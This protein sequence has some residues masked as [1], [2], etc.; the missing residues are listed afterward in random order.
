MRFSS[1]KKQ[2]VPFYFCPQQHPPRQ[3]KPALQDVPASPRTRSRPPIFY[4]Y[5]PDERLSRNFPQLQYHAP[6]PPILS[7]MTIVLCS[8]VAAVLLLH[9]S[10]TNN[11]FGA[12]SRHK[13]SLTKSQISADLPSE[14][15]LP[16]NSQL[17]INP[18]SHEQAI[19]SYGIPTDPKYAPPPIL[20][21]GHLSEH[22][23][24]TIR[25]QTK[26]SPRWPFETSPLVRAS[27]LRTFGPAF[28]SIVISDHAKLLYIP[29]FNAGNSHIMKLMLHFIQPSFNAFDN[30][31]TATVHNALHDMS[32]PFWK[33]AT[34]YK[35][36]TEQLAEK[37]KDPLLL[38]FGFV[39]NPYHRLASVYVDRILHSPIDSNEYLM[40]INNLF[41]NDDNRKNIA[42]VSKPSFQDFVY[43]I[44]DVLASP[45]VQSKDLSSPL[46]YENDQTRRDIHWRPQVELLHPDLIHLDF[47][48][49]YETM[50]TDQDVLTS[51]AYQ[52][53]LKSAPKLP[54]PGDIQVNSMEKASLLRNIYDDDVLKRTVQMIYKDDFIY[55][56]YSTE[57][58]LSL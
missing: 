17:N 20:P 48:G 47:V 15:S 38:K 7:I 37:L 12:T 22:L 51:W 50:E 32:H 14:Y 11:Q 16:Q 57:V 44:R 41:G 42:Q 10:L 28:A 23:L 54:S 40:Q 9:T 56:G 8:A 53:S 24:S 31:N 5:R 29:T 26:L 21:R 3:T 25:S 52:H 19:Q 58:P 6:K 33:N 27:K 34:V 55:F 36:S 30:L 39:R 4:T 43:A 49:R 18:I 13:A 45:R 35:L 1:P 46:A 2:T